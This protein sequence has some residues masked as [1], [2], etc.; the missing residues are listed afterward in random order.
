MSLTIKLA[1][2]AQHIL[3]RSQHAVLLH[4][5]AVGHSFVCIQASFTLTFMLSTLLSALP[6]AY[7]FLL[8]YGS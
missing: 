5:G 4:V 7:P 1:N 6:L 3:A 8:T 2:T